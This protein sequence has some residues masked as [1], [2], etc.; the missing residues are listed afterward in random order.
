M[1]NSEKLQHMRHSAAHLL[2]AAVLR[3][4]PDTKLTIGPAIENGFYYDFEFS[5]PISD[6]DFPKI[7]KMMAKTL[8]DWTHFVR[9]EV[10]KEEA[11]EYYKQNPYKLELLDDIVAK[12]EP[13]TF[14][15]I[16]HFEDLC[17]GGHSENPKDDIGAFKLLS[18]AGAYWR[19]SEKNKMLTRIYATASPHKKN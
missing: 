3:L 4:W 17:R 19:G 7:E 2:A 6:S 1:E 9:R 10:T 14:Y 5:N 12:N 16:G 8:A 13:I 11:R 18:L 15:K